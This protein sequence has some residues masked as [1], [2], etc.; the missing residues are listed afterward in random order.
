MTVRN[1]EDQ[2]MNEDKREKENKGTVKD[3]VTH[4]NKV[5]ILC[6]LYVKGVSEKNL[7]GISAT[8]L[9]VA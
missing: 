3:K 9:K 7:P 4:D 8:R 1:D 5:E 2:E 6:L